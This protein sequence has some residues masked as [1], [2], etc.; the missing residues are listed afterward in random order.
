MTPFEKL[1][2]VAPQ[3]E[4]SAVLQLMSET[5][6]NQVPVVVRNRIIGI[7]SRADILRLIQV[8]RA[9]AVEN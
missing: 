6:V 5:D 8:R 3:D 4:A 1:R 2:T 9:V 7:I